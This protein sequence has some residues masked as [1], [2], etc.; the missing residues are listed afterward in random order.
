MAVFRS[1]LSNRGSSIRRDARECQRR[2]RGAAIEICGPQY[3]HPKWLTPFTTYRSNEVARRCGRI[4]PTGWRS[5]ATVF[6]RIRRNATI[7][8]QVSVT[9]SGANHLDSAE[10]GFDQEEAWGSQTMNPD[11]PD[12][13]EIGYSSSRKLPLVALTAATPPHGAAN[14]LR[15]VIEPIVPE[16][17]AMGFDSL[18]ILV[19]RVAANAEH[20]AAPAPTL[21]RASK[22]EPQRAITMDCAVRIADGTGA[23]GS[24]TRWLQKHGS[25]FLRMLRGGYITGKSEPIS[26]ISSRIGQTACS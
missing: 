19:G 12:D 9:Q 10:V 2:W 16:S 11:M 22:A 25:V 14:D 6:A 5:Q 23:K 20:G 1:A 24:R 13:V 18:G 26:S 7:R 4:G 15:V 21:R 8:H 17:M 3:A